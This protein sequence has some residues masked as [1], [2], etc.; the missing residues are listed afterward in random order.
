MVTVITGVHVLAIKME[1]I[2]V[3]HY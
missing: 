3:I 2:L 1:P